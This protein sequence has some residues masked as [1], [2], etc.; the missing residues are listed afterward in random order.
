M[1]FEVS[2]QRQHETVAVDDTGFRRTQRRYAGKLRLHALRGSCIDDF[3]PLYAVDLR[4]VED[5]FEPRDLAC[6]RR[7]D[8]LSALAMRHAMGSQNVVEHAPAARTVVGAQ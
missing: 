4:L 2:T 5:P 1:I 7:D 3:D 6:I 8:E